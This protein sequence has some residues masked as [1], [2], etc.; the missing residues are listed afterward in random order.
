MGTIALLFHDVYVDTPCESGFQ[1]QAADRYKL[2]VPQFEAQLGGLAAKDPSTRPF[3]ITV[4]DGGV[5]YYTVIADRLES[6]GWRGRC[7]V[8]TDA[9]GRRGFLDAA[10]IRELHSRGHVIGS[11]TA[12]HPSRFSACSEKE[13]RDEWSRS[14]H[15]LEDILGGAVILGS[16]P[17]GYYSRRVAAA[18]RE[19]GLQAIFTSEPTTATH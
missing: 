6:L 18:A 2:S 12:S 16:V 10:Q 19:A 9:I 8:S 3:V 13:M 11:H 17:G 14:R 4:D 1:S 5:S 7:F 15:V